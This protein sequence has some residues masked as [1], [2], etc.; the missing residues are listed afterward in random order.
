MSPTIYG[1]GSGKF[2]RTSIQIPTLI[3]TAIKSGQAVV[4]GEGTGVWDAVHIDDLTT[5]YELLLVKAL[6]GENI[7]SG[8]KGIYFSETG[9][10]S[11]KQLSQGLA[12]EL[13]KQGLIKTKEVKS[14]S[15]QEGAD[16]WAGGNKQFVELGFGSK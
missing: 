9:D 3:R 14:L 16:L 8:K 7:P 1:E 15:L 11:W 2:N 13:Y 4:L 6:A 12:D 10:Y 5:L